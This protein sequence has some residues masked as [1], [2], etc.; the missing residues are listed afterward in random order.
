MGT[1]KE[2]QPVK[3]FVALLS[4]HEELF[5]SVERNLT[6]LFG[7]IESSSGPFPWTATDYYE[8]EMGPELQR[9]FVSFAPLISPERLPEIKL[10][11]QGL[12]ENY[13]WI[14][15]ER[16]K[17]R[18]NIDP[19]YLD[20]GKVVLASTK[21]ASHRIYLG[22]GI[23]GEITLLFH[24]GSFQS[25]SYTYPDYVWPETLSFLAALR[26]LYLNQLKERRKTY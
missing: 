12:E 16:R 6:T 1:P 7:S 24:S 21:N 15:T 17:R 8:E 3:L 9:R 19:G 11:T 13:Q 26:S 4:H 2:P 14:G 18:V 5:P 10:R 22:S 20:V 25:F 23:W